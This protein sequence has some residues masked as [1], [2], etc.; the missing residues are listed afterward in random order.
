MRDYASWEDGRLTVVG[1]DRLSDDQAAAIAEIA[2]DRNGQIKVKLHSKE[3][4]L[5]NLARH[6]GLFKDKLEHTASDD[7]KAFLDRI[8]DRGRTRAE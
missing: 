3:A 1:S 8:S 5:V 7:I 6:F 4:A 2:M